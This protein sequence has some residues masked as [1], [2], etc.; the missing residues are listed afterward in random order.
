MSSNSINNSHSNNVF[1]EL[2]NKYST[3]EG[4]RDFLTSADGG[5]LN[6]SEVDGITI[7]SYKSKSADG[8][9]IIPTEEAFERH[10]HLE[11]FQRV[12]WDTQANLPLVVAPLRCRP[13]NA[14]GKT[15]AEVLENFVITPYHE[16]LIQGGFNVCEHDKLHMPTFDGEWSQTPA[17]SDPRKVHTCF[18]N[19]LMCG[20][21][22]TIVSTVSGNSAGPI[23]KGSVYIDGTIETEELYGEQVVFDDDLNMSE[24]FEGAF[25]KFMARQD[26]LYPGWVLIQKS[27]GRR[28]VKMGRFYEEARDYKRISRVAKFRLL[29]LR[30]RGDLTHYLNIFPGEVGL[31]DEL[32]ERIHDVTRE[33]LDNYLARWQAKTKSW[34]DIPK[35]YHKHI[36]AINNIYHTELKPKRWVVRMPTVITYINEL[37]AAQLLF[38][39]NRLGAAQQ[40]NPVVAVE[41]VIAADNS[42]ETSCESDCCD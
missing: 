11:W 6:V 17:M 16:G 33:L 24:E 21:N 29:E 34:A 13:F 18:M 15:L 41:D 19:Y 35:Q 37:P 10:P 32:K 40:T 38:L 28:F 25:N 9:V 30:R 23:Q 12:A 1:A 14:D 2:R 8:K 31:Y 3:W 5:A 22:K 7:I 26:L 4:L 20:P 39:V 36:A 42:S 27:T